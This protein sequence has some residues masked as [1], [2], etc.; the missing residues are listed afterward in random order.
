MAID[1]FG[2][3][4]RNHFPWEPAL[5]SVRAGLDL[6]PGLETGQGILTFCWELISAICSSIFNLFVDIYKKIHVGCP[7]VFLDTMF[8]IYLHGHL[9]EPASLLSSNLSAHY[10]NDFILLWHTF[11]A[12]LSFYSGISRLK[13]TN[14]KH[15][16]KT[17]HWKRPWCCRRKI[18]DLWRRDVEVRLWLDGITHSMDISLSKLQGNSEGRVWHSL[19]VQEYKYQTLKLTDQTTKSFHC[20][21]ESVQVRHSSIIPTYRGPEDSPTLSIAGCWCPSSCVLLLTLLS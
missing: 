8:M 7:S 10:N 11:Y 19:Q 20:Y 18:K 16:V 12:T 6:A 14:N 2:E 13:M 15:L 9:W 17:A 5:I 21:W 1:A 3:A 4:I